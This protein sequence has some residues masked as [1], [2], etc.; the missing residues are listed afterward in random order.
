MRE[1]NIRDISSLGGNPVYVAV[2]VLFWLFGYPQVAYQ[3]AAGL[4]L[5]YLTTT[6][7]RI[8]FFRQRPKKQQF[9]NVLEKIDASSFPSLHSM[10]AAVLSTAIAMFF[11]QPAVWLLAAV[12]AASVAA[13]RVMLMRH[14]RTD[15]IAGLIIGAAIALASPTALSVIGL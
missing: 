11:S 4:A 5:C 12:T 9:R 13:T 10:R 2:A 14:H 1:E 6:I 7:L 15:A 8:A 3:L